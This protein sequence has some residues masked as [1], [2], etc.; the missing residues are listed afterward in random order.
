MDGG[1]PLGVYAGTN[2][3][4]VF[5]SRDEGDTWHTL[6]DRLPPVLSV[7]AAVIQA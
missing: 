3:G 1:N 2:T 5:Y 4:Q 7:S 6:A